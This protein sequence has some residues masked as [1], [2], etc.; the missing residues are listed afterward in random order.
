MT[1]LMHHLKENVICISLAHL[2][3]LKISMYLFCH[4]VCKITDT[5]SA[6]D[7]LAQLPA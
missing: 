5:D 6:Y 4:I 7:N 1:T 3:L 2:R